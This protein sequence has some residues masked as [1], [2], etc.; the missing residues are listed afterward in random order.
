MTLK[1]MHDVSDTHIHTYTHI[2]VH[3]SA[4][5]CTH[6]HTHLMPYS[7]S[8]DHPIYIYLS[9]WMARKSV[10]L[11]VDKKYRCHYLAMLGHDPPHN[12][13]LT[14]VSGQRDIDE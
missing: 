11:Y 10:R 3:T 2:H 7:T 14:S 1:C 12:M 8:Y 6:T 4:L 13:S 9:G 5:A